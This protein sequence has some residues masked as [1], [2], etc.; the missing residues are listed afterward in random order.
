ME[1]QFLLYY[2]EH[3]LMLYAVPKFTFILES[4]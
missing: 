1:E 3:G 4:N 2:T